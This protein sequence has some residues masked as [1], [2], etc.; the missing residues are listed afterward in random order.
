MD[1]AFFENW[2][3]STAKDEAV[4]QAAAEY[5]WHLNMWLVPR[6]SSIDG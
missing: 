1:S 5:L 6:Q 2:L 4:Y 3:V